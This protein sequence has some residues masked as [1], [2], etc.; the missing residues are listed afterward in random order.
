MRQSP[1]FTAALLP[2]VQR[3]TVKPGGWT[4]WTDVYYISREA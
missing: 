2:S 4:A 3:I 1:I